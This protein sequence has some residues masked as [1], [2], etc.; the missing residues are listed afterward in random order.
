MNLLG[1][2]FIVTGGASGIGQ[3]LAVEFMK[4][5]ASVAIADMNE[6]GLAETKALASK[7]ARANSR[8]STHKLDVSRLEDWQEFR[9]NV[10]AEHGTIDGIINNAGVAMSISIEDMAYDQLDWM[11]SI[12]FN[13]MV[14]GTKE[15]L[16]LLK[17]RPDAII[18]NVSSVFGLFSA[19]SQ[20]A[21][22]A[23]KFAICGFTNCLEQ[24]LKNTNVTVSS[25]HPGHIGT[26]IVHNVKTIGRAPVMDRSEEEISAIG[27]HFK[28][29]GL[30]PSEAAKIIIDGLQQKKRKICV[31]RD[32]V[33]ADR[34]N[35]WMPGWFV[36]F[37]NRKLENGISPDKAKTA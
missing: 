17:E 31:G 20:S 9:D 24:E 28:D 27:H 33:W 6:A 13:G 30:A 7:A 32:A 18:A 2:T 35:R 5:G 8:V 34:F 22:C 29:T 23:S 12:N 26:N 1:K 21:Y 36:D 14:Y 11:M 3:A 4:R 19:K 25:I 10:I 15:F 16:P 37:A